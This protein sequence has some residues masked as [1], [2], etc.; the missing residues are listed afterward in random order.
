[1]EYIAKSPNYYVLN[2]LP[3]EFRNNKPYF[4]NLI[5]IDPEIIYLGD[6]V[7]IKDDEVIVK[8]AIQV[9]KQRGIQLYSHSISERLNKIYGLPVPDG[10]CAGKFDYCP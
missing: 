7:S 4:Q 3:S 6:P 5:K 1:V 9:A 8:Q 2:D 10:A